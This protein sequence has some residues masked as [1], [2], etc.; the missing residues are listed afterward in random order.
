MLFR[1]DSEAVFSLCERNQ[2]DHNA[3]LQIVL[4]PG[5]EKAKIQQSFLSRDNQ[6]FVVHLKVAALPIPERIT[7]EEI[8]KR[9]LPVAYDE[10][11]VLPRKNPKPRLLLREPVTSDKENHI[12]IES[13]SPDGKRVL[14]Y[15]IVVRESRG[16]RDYYLL[17]L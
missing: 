8:L 14:L 17:P 3:T 1:E 2:P 13:L 16:E 11:W 6:T 12:Y 4:P 9:K 7:W 5:R 15:Q 10:I